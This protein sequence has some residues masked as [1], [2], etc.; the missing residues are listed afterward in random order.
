MSILKLAIIVIDEA[1][2]VSAVSFV[3]VD[4]GALSVVARVLKV[5]ST[6]PLNFAGK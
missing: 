4:E 3:V 6:A 2:R 5:P 1:I